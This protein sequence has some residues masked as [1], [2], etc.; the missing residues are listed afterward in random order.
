MNKETLLKSAL[1]KDRIYLCSF[2]L[3]TL[4]SGKLLFLSSKPYSARVGEHTLTLP[5]ANPHW[6]GSQKAKPSPATSLLEKQWFLSCWTELMWNLLICSIE[7]DIQ[8]S[9]LCVETGFCGNGEMSWKGP[10]RYSASVVVQRGRA[11]WKAL[12]LHYLPPAHQQTCVF[13]SDMGVSLLEP[14]EE[15][16]SHGLG[17]G[18]GLGSVLS[19]HPVASLT[20]VKEAAVT[21]AV[22]FRAAWEVLRSDSNELHRKAYKYI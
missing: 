4:D 17:L 3:K 6:G 15:R 13:F 2:I 22:L 18:C 9:I 10:G 7:V 14:Q 19:R 20:L 5:P 8:K 21:S 1:K 16:S 11:C 12:S